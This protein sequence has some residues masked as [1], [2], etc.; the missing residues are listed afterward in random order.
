MKVICNQTRIQTKYLIWLTI[1]NII[2]IGTGFMTKGLLGIG[3]GFGIS[4]VVNLILFVSYRKTLNRNRDYVSIQMGAF[5][6]TRPHSYYEI[7]LVDIEDFFVRL[8]HRRKRNLR[9]IKV[10]FNRDQ[11]YEFDIDRNQLGKLETVVKRPLNYTLLPINYNQN[12]QKNQRKIW[13]Q[14]LFSIIGIGLTALGIYV[15]HQEVGTTINALMIIVVLLY[16]TGHY[17]TFLSKYDPIHVKLIYI[18]LG[19]LIYIAIVFSIIT[20]FSHFV[21]GSPFSID[22]MMYSIYALSS[23]VVVFL[24]LMAALYI[25]S[26][27]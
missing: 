14:I 8:H 9:N 13:Y 22:Y 15:Y 21:L 18:V 19:I 25:L 27:A 1:I 16:S 7:P 26:Y 24:I 23:F 2:S 20:V 17:Y 10:V 3:I 5:R 12:V 4:L 6:H 11:V